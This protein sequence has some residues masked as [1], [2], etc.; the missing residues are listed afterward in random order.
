MNLLDRCGVRLATRER[1]QTIK[2]TFTNIAGNQTCLAQAG[3]GMRYELEL[4]RCMLGTVGKGINTDSGSSN[5][6]DIYMSYDTMRKY[7]L[8]KAGKNC[9]T[10]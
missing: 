10:E 8:E 2:S 3:L 9:I 7:L 4:G 1:K 6:V 5:D